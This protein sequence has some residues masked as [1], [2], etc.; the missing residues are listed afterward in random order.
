[1][2]ALVDEFGSYVQ[3][4]AAVL[5]QLPRPHEMDKELRERW[6]N[7]Q[8]RLRHV[9]MTALVDEVGEETDLN[10][11]IE[12]VFTVEV[13][14]EKL[15]FDRRHLGRFLNACPSL[16]AP[17]REV[18]KKTRRDWLSENNVGKA[19]VDLVE[20]VLSIHGLWLG[21]PIPSKQASALHG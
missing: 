17:V 12:Q 1:M 19:V 21:M 15:G 13:C 11:P 9:L 3:F 2:T 10:T 6:M 16:K 20:R 8:A 7:R 4:Q 5:R 14:C 18:V